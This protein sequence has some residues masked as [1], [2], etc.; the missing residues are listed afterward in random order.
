MLLKL[1]NWCLN[2]LVVL[3]V[4]V[5]FAVATTDTCVYMSPIHVHACKYHLPYSMQ[6]HADSSCRGD[7]S[8]SINN[9]DDSPHLWTIVKSSV[10]QLPY[11]SKS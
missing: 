11:V 4:F 1:R 5:T 9:F 8:I 3:F 10:I 7:N 6:P 2:F